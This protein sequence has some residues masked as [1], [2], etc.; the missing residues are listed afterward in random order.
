[1]DSYLQAFYKIIWKERNKE[2]IEDDKFTAAYN[3]AMDANTN[4]ITKQQIQR[5]HTPIPKIRLKRTRDHIIEIET[6]SQRHIRIKCKLTIPTNKQIK[7][8]KIKRHIQITK[9]TRNH[10]LPI[11]ILTRRT[12]VQTTPPLEPLIPRRRKPPDKQD[13]PNKRICAKALDFMEMCVDT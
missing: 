4:E 13:T 12:T 10:Q 5:N 6:K 7:I 1:M 9:H 2:L 3:R 8:I 11:L